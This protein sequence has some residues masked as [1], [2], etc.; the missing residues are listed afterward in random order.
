MRERQSLQ[1]PSNCIQGCY[2]TKGVC[3]DPG[4][5][6][7]KIGVLIGS[8]IVEWHFNPKM[9]M[10]SKAASTKLPGGHAPQIPP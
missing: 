4:R 8:G 9:K 3:L 5:L 6:F 10:F 1:V 2:V 7:P